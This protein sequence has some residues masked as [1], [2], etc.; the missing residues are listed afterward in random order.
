MQLFGVVPVSLW[1]AVILLVGL[2]LVAVLWRPMVARTEWRPLPMAVAGICVTAVLALT[3]GAEGTA[4]SAPM[5]G[6][7]EEVLDEGVAHAM[8]EA[9][10][11]LE[12]I[13]NLV[14]LVPLGAALVLGLRRIIVPLVIVLMLP[15]FTELVQLAIPGRVG[16]L[17]DFLLNA[18]GGIIGVGLGAILARRLRRN[19]AA[20]AAESRA[21]PLR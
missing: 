14:L 1:T 15:A 11:D 12:T 9:A 16:S 17:S 4:T 7:V 3:L 20:V 5:G 8:L 2:A 19:S 6:L 10:Q 21:S 18:L 13:L